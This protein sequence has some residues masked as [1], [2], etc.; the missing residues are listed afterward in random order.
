MAKQIENTI[1]NYDQ[2]AA[3]SD[4]A[5]SHIPDGA[6]SVVNGVVYGT[7]EVEAVQVING[8]ARPAGTVKIVTAT[9]L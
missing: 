4:L 6:A 1:P 7:R 9:K 3:P 5:R 8:V 2:V